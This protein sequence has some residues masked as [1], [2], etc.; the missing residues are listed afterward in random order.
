MFETNVSDEQIRAKLG[1]ESPI[2]RLRNEITAAARKQSDDAARTLRLAEVSREINVLFDGTVRSTLS[3]GRYHRGLGLMAGLDLGVSIGSRTG[4]SYKRL[5]PLPDYVDPDD[6]KEGRLTLGMRFGAV[7]MVGVRTYFLGLFAGLRPMYT[8]FSIGHFFSEG[9]AIPLAGRLELRLQERV[10]IIVEGWWG[11]I[12]KSDNTHAGA[13]LVLPLTS[14]LDG[15]GGVWLHARFD[16]IHIPARIP[17]LFEKDDI[18]VPDVTT[19][20]GSLGI[21]I[22]F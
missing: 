12:G 4:E 16:Q 15:S 19:T 9:G 18:Y 8:N 10:P 5:V 20:S 14:A 6:G 22:G 11:H 2:G 3:T 17:G 13:T 1:S 21:A 7:A